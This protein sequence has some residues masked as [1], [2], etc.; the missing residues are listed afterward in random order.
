MSDI[1]GGQTTYQPVAFF[2]PRHVTADDT[3]DP[4]TEKKIF[5]VFL[6]LLS[7]GIKNIFTQFLS[8]FL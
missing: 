8:H 4:E 7:E 6:R 2:K 1:Y 5:V 3:K